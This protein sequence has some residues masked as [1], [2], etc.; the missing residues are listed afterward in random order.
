MARVHAAC[1]DTCGRT[2]APLRLQE[3]IP[4]ANYTSPRPS[5]AAY[6]FWVPGFT[7]K[8]VVRRCA[9]A[10]KSTMVNDEAEPTVI[11]L[12]SDNDAASFTDDDEMSVID[13]CFEGEDKPRWGEAETG[14]VGGVAAPH[15]NNGRCPG[16]NWE[17]DGVLDISFE[18]VGVA[19][20]RSDKTDGDDGAE[21]EDGTPARV[22][23]ESTLDGIGKPECSPNSAW[24]RI[25]ASPD[26]HAAG[27]PTS[28]SYVQL[29]YVERRPV[30]GPR[31]PVE[32]PSRNWRLGGGI[33][34]PFPR[35]GE[36]LYS[37][38]F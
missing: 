14:A 6:T 15:G 9:R 18:V 31:L 5:P 19:K 20:E 26:R 13:L 25:A 34:I 36:S 22:A 35:K 37:S 8:N 33:I 3:R 7:R 16:K 38:W 23:G 30:F 11:I 32:G 10:K 28:G 29:V 2:P 1:A 27:A 24:G 17:V 21:V 4:S 12:C